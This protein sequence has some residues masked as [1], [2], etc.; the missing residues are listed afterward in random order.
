M[1]FVLLVVNFIPVATCSSDSILPY[2]PNIMTLCSRVRHLQ[3]ESVK[4]L[5]WLSEI[6][7][8][9]GKTIFHCKMNLCNQNVCSDVRSR[10]CFQDLTK[11]SAYWTKIKTMVL[12]ASCNKED[13]WTDVVDDWLLHRIIESFFNA[14]HTTC[15]WGRQER[16]DF[17]DS[18]ALP[19]GLDQT[20]PHVTARHRGLRLVPWDD[21]KAN[22]SVL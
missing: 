7:R 14:P 6:W 5:E 9:R 21:K 1:G 19:G 8:V 17:V 2:R 15:W 16:D 22:D 3:A 20:C 13:C 4:Q 11:N 12:Y 18:G 10:Q